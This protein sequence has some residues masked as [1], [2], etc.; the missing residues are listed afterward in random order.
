MKSYSKNPRTITDKQKRKLESSM[1]EL[2][3]IS[4]IVHDLT[5]DE[6][7]CGNQRMRAIGF[8]DSDIKIT[9]TY[10]TPLED[11]TVSI[12][13]IE[14]D[15]IRLNYRAV[16]FSEY[17]RG[18]AS[19][20]ANKLGGEFN[21]EMFD[22]FDDSILEICGFEKMEKTDDVLRRVKAREERKGI[23]LGVFSLHVDNDTFEAYCD[24]LRS[25]DEEG[26]L[27]ELFLEDLGV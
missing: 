22:L 20:S 7:I 11:G 26:D 4:G 24:Y 23:L 21:E 12:G 10:E 1:K 15:G 9:E 25:K 17:Q 2:G 3:D 18:L 19:L 14:K 16:K 6:V 8:T 5:T 27:M 13:F